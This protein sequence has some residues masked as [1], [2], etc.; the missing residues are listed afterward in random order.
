MPRHGTPETRM[1]R[2]VSSTPMD[3]RAYP[4]SLSLPNQ[5][6]RLHSS[7]ATSR[8]L[9][10]TRPMSVE[11]PLD[12]YFNASPPSGDGAHGERQVFGRSFASPRGSE[13]WVPGSRISFTAISASPGL[14]PTPR[15]AFRSA[16][17]DRP[18]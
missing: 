9:Q 18:P 8:R 6:P 1:Y 12:L 16:P 7:P 11:G 10:T 15:I 14:A 4:R 17:I 2:S 5:I 3:V 13:R